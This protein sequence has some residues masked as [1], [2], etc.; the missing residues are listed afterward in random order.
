MQ[1]IDRLKKAPVVEDFF[2]R[3][4]KCVVGLVDYGGGVLGLRV[5]AFVRVHQPAVTNNHIIH[6]ACSFPAVSAPHPIAHL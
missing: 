2:D 6:H 5:R 3:G 4:G 1:K